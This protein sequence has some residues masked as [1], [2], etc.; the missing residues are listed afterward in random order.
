M[1]AAAGNKPWRAAVTRINKGNGRSRGS[2]RNK[3]SSRG[4]NN[5]VN[6]LEAFLGNIKA[7]REGVVA[8]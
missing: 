4:N 3:G 7:G 6:G 5:A 2:K 8:V 1:V